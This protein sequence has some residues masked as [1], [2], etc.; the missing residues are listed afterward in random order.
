METTPASEGAEAKTDWSPGGMLEKLAARLGS[1]DARTIYG[2]P[3]ERNGMTVIPVAKVRYGFG[4]GAGRKRSAGD[5]G[6]G[7]GGGVNV[8]PVGYIEMSHD[9]V[10]F[11]RIR[12]PSPAL[13]AL[14]IGFGLFLLSRVLRAALAHAR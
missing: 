10:R 6:T 9:R 3:I 4:G 13:A 8:T 2:I 14:G 7:A 12:T 1:A 5:E 11:R